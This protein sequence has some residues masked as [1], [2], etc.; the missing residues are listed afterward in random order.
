MGGVEGRR[1]RGG[2]AP[3]R[4]ADVQEPIAGPGELRVLGAV[5]EDDDGT[6][7]EPSSSTTQF[8]ASFI[9]ILEPSTNNSAFIFLTSM[10]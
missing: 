6:Q 7:K 8:P 4:R 10:R 5:A 9:P 2:G 1:A 3:G